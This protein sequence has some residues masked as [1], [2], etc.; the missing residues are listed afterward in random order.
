MARNDVLVTRFLPEQLP[1]MLFV[2]LA[3]PIDAD[4]SLI[5]GN[6]LEAINRFATELDSTITGIVLE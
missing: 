2:E 1:A 4:V 5:T 3:P 6:F